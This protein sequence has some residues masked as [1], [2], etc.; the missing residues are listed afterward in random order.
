[1]SQDP[2]EVVRAQFVATNERDFQ[3]AMDLYADDV[4][5][6]HAPAKVR[7]ILTAALRGR[8]LA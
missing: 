6:A 3:R 1:M 8:V 7:R 2:I 4:D 5:P